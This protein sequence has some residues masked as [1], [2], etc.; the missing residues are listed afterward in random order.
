[1][2]RLLEPAH[3]GQH[4]Q[5]AQL[6][7]GPFRGVDEAGQVER[8]AAGGGGGAG[9][10]VQRFIGIFTTCEHHAPVI[11]GLADSSHEQT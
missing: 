10:L 7:Q 9:A 6:E 1:M 2:P 5:V 11:D 8:S 4:V 3:L